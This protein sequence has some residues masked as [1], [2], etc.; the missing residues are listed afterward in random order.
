MPEQHE[1]GATER[2][3]ME[4]NQQLDEFEAA[5]LRAQ[6]TV[7]ESDPTGPYDAVVIQPLTVTP[8]E[9]EIH[10]PGNLVWE[11]PVLSMWEPPVPST[12]GTLPSETPDGPPIPA[13]AV[14]VRLDGTPIMPGDPDNNEEAMKAKKAKEE[15]PA[16]KLTNSEFRV[17]TDLMT[18]RQFLD[19]RRSGIRDRTGV[20]NLNHNQDYYLDAHNNTT[21]QIVRA[22]LWTGHEIIADRTA[23]NVSDSWSFALLDAGVL[24]NEP[25]QR[26]M[27]LEVCI[28][29]T[30]VQLMKVA[31]Q[32]EIV[33]GHLMA[34]F[35]RLPPEELITFDQLKDWVE[36]GFHPPRFSGAQ[37]RVYGRDGNVVRGP[38]ATAAERAQ[39]AN[40][41]IFAIPVTVTDVDVGTCTYRVNRRGV[42][43][44]H[45]SRN[46]V[47]SIVT[48]H[49]TLEAMMNYVNDI[50]DDNALGN[51]EM[52]QVGEHTYGNH[53]SENN[54]D[55]TVQINQ[56][57]LKRQLT[58]YIRNNYGPEEA[59]QII[60]E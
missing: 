52:Q 47:S 13:K 3:A 29:A 55:P 58:T 27:Q 32:N 11:P 24:A 26:K 40:P 9:Q 35:G 36:F 56:E 39:A 37:A 43:S 1:P 38:A 45:F 44:H 33:R 18:M 42:Y 19:S 5:L 15:K 17:V 50:V 30:L 22:K 7:P 20:V 46:E 21:N 28:N 10:P 25:P 34:I 59:S 4:I 14:G 60:G 23:G 57:E 41:N 48:N 51:V 6:Q 53:D 8:V 2:Q 12:W 49:D 31:P 54:E 16:F